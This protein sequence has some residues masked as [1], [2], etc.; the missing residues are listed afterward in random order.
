M[1]L[2]EMVDQAYQEGKDAF[3]DG[4]KSEDNPYNS[5]DEDHQWEAWNEG[6]Y[7]ASWDN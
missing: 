3:Y 6:Y 2:Q 5:V 4:K 1:N 7:N